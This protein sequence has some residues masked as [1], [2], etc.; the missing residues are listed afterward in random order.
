MMSLNYLDDPLFDERPCPRPV[1]CTAQTVLYFG[2]SPVS[3]LLDWC[4]TSSTIPEEI[5]CM[6]ISRTLETHAS[7]RM[8]LGD[9]LC[10]IDEKNR[11]TEPTK[12]V[13]IGSQSGIQTRYALHL[14]AEFVPG[15]RHSGSDEFSILDIYFKVLFQGSANVSGVLLGFPTLDIP[16][17]G[18]DHVLT[19]RRHYFTE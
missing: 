13:G 12:V 15:G 11:Y 9:R 16:P 17:H 18:L 5:A 19:E 6:L 3:A 8:N 1:G 14:R 10:P 4:A 2:G 7:G